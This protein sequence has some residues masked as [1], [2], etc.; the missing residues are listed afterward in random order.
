[1]GGNASWSAARFPAVPLPGRAA[2]S[3]STAAREASVADVSDEVL[4]FRVC[5]GDK[6]SLALLFQRYAR[7]VRSVARRILRDDTEA[8]DL[9]QDV[10]L[11][12]QRKCSVYDSS[13]S[14]AGSWI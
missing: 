8:D 10:F 7:P 3:T 1:M 12:I 4:L 6:D 13:K 9:V 11:F 14:S 2:A 5:S